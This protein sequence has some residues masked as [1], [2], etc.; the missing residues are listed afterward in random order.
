[1]HS[2]GI[3]CMECIAFCTCFCHSW[4]SLQIFCLVETV[5]KAFSCFC[6]FLLNLLVVLCYLVF[7]EHICTITLLGIAVI[8]EW[9]VECIHVSGSFPDGR[10][11][12]DSGVDSHDILV[13]EHHALPP[14][15]LYIVLQFHTVLTI[16]VDSSESIVNLT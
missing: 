14:I 10:V 16:V 9:V 15:L 12:K 8:D 7:N 11:H 2:F 3:S 1:M 13:H 5:T 6:H 4:R